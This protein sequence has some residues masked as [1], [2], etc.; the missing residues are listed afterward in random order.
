MSQS[1]S[2]FHGREDE[3][4][5]LVHYLNRA[6]AGDQQ[7][8]LLQG[9]AGVGKT[10]LLQAFA[11][12]PR[13]RR[14]GPRFFY[15]RA[16][17]G[18]V[19][20]PVHHAALAAT[21]RRLYAKLGGKQQATEMARGLMG[22]WLGVIPIWG[23]LLGAVAGTVD[24]LRR[25]K[26]QRAFE[27]IDTLDED[28]QALLE[29]SRRRPLVL[30]LDELERADEAAIARLAALIETA[31]EGARILIVGAYRPTAPGIA[32]P[33]VHSLRGTLPH[34]GEFFLHLPLL[35]LAADAVAD[36]LAHQLPGADIPAELTEWI[37]KTTG[38]HP[39]AI[40]STLSHLQEIG[41][42]R[43]ESGGWVL[44]LD[45]L[46]VS[47]ADSPLADLRAVEPGTAEVV[48]VA[49]LLGAEFDSVTLARLLE[50][51]ELAVEDDLALGMRY[52][53]LEC[54]GE[55]ELQSG[56]VAT[57][58]RFASPHLHA[59]LRQALPAERQASLQARL[60]RI[61]TRDAQDPPLGPV[62]I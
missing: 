52:G 46:E 39:A 4:A 40:E 57:A 62:R 20:R 49:S 27:E 23:D 14:R 13:K 61:R 10:A 45:R 36:W 25:R 58:Y 41:A 18:E 56:D 26:R 59:T 51:D 47:A 16:P 28:I 1:I 32:D 24:V 42:I 43:R 22:E 48:Q 15:L 44:D 12:R 54:R 35:G 38:G 55:L 50:R 7:L 21:S 19:Y 34:K 11:R 6:V 2:A 30:L 31:D 9:D 8:V 53:L 5:L 33:P 37:V 3:M 17:E 29:A 60:V